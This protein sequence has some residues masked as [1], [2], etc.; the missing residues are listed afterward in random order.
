MC[1]KCPECPECGQMIA[2]P[3]TFRY[4]G[5]LLSIPFLGIAAAFVAFD[6]GILNEFLLGFVL[7]MILLGGTMLLR[8][9]PHIGELMAEKTDDTGDK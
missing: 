5:G 4:V 6:H 3:A 9:D 2:Q 1:D 8:T 7:G